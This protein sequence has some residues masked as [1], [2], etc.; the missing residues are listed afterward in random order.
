MWQM[1]LYANTKTNMV[2]FLNG[3]LKLKTFKL[4]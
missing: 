1:Y 2:E 3:R 4:F